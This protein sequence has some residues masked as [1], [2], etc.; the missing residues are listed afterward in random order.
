LREQWNDGANALA[1][2][3]GQVMS[4]SRND[5]TC[6]ALEESGVEVVSFR[7]GELVRGRGGARC[8]T[9]PLQRDPA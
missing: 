6:R 5:R 7:G 1:L 4:Y 9:M 3:P 8:M 2:K